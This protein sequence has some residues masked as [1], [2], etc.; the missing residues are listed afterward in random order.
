MQYKHIGAYRGPV[1]DFHTHLTLNWHT[2]PHHAWQRNPATRDPLAPALMQG[3]WQR[4]EAMRYHN[5]IGRGSLFERT[6]ERITHR[7]VRG[8]SR[9]EGG[10]LVTRMDALG[11][12]ASVL[13]AVPPVVP[14]EA[15]LAAATRTKRLIPFISPCP[16]HPPEPQIERLL[17]AGGR[18]IK[19][20]PILQDVRVGGPYALRM[21]QAAA[22]HR[23]PLVV[24]AGGSG[25]LFGLPE[26]PRTDPAEF[27]RLARRVP[28]AT[29][30]IAHA[31][32]W[33]CP[34]Y[35]R[36]VTP[37]DN[38]WLD[39]SFQSPAHIGLLRRTVGIRRLL[40]GSDSPMGQVRIV[41]ENCVRAGLDEQ[42]LRTLFYDNPRRLLGDAT[43]KDIVCT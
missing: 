42:E 9:E 19:L 20:H 22:R 4:F 16:Q 8:F 12:T 32:L 14:N 38:L 1:V 39:V 41:L 3:F 37:V 5:L 24:H 34:E 7:I 15:V 17:A 13:L 29:I 33:E 25:V 26:R 21:A 11:V 30:V 40:L 43:M 10:D 27:V 6:V 28:D 35:V 31:G 18:G 2:L 36:A 23:V